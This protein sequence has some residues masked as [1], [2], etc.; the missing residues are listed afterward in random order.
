MAT[1][2]RRSPTR[3]ARPRCSRVIQASRRNSFA[4]ALDLHAT[5]E[6]PFERAQIQ[7]RAGVALA[8]ASEREPA[9]ERLGDAYRSARKLGSRPLAAA[10]ATEVEGLGESVERRLGRRAAAAAEGGGLSRRELEVLR[11]AAEWPAPTGR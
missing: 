8:A 3:S 4:R 2:S 5:L 10:A 1:R 11:L 7:L 9:L 6:I